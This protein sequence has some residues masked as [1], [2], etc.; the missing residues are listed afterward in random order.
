MS[1]F[2]DSFRFLLTCVARWMNQRRRQRSIEESRVSREQLG[3]RRLRLTDDRRRLAEGQGPI[4]DF[5][6]RTPSSPT[7]YPPLPAFAVTYTESN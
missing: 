5:G 7:A 1:T 4:C 3:D 6:C 2:L